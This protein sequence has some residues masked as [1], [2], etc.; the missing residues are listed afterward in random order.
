MPITK[1]VKMPSYEYSIR[2]SLVPWGR[3]TLTLSLAWACGA[4]ILLIHTYMY[5]QIYSTHGLIQGWRKN[6]NFQ[7]FPMKY[8]F[9]LISILI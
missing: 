3:T 2:V 8:I 7:H 6:N 4:H 5:R 1:S 9:Q